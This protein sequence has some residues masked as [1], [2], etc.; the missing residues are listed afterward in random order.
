M[1]TLTTL[2][3]VPATIST[4]APARPAARRTARSFPRTRFVHF[5]LPATEIF[6]VQRLHGRRGFVVIRH[7]YETKSPRSPRF[8]VDGDVHSRD[9]P[10]RF[11][12][13][14]EVAFR[15][16]EGHVA[17]E[18]ILHTRPSRAGAFA[19]GTRQCADRQKTQFKTGSIRA[20]TLEV[21]PAEFPAR[22]TL[23]SA[24]IL[25]HDCP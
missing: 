14:F 12:E 25:Y 4:R 2:A 1:S 9:L 3:A 8:P 19:R 7:F 18:Q 5:Q 21:S 20:G 16:L 13:S 15:G 6:S 10:V 17:H 22:R 23:K 24:A 11:E